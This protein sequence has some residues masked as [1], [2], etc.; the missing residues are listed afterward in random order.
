MKIKLDTTGLKQSKW[1][2]YVVRFAFGGTVTAL[3]GIIAK[4]CG[5]EIGGLFLAFPAILPASATLIEKHELEKKERA[6]KHGAQRARQAAGV[7]A[8][9]AAMG[10]VALGVFAV[11]VWLGLPSA[12]MA[13]VLAGAT[14]AWFVVAISVWKLRDI[15][16]RRFRRWRLRQRRVRAL[17]HR[18]NDGHFRESHLR[19]STNERNR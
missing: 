12:E 6:G 13:K 16:W 9:G 19:R 4:K 15:V 2:E 10:S 18:T 11:I 7:D 8:I 3:A 1:Y 17:S 14:I 5:P